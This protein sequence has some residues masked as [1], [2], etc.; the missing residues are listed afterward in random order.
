MQ[1]Q[2]PESVRVISPN[3]EG[4]PTPVTPDLAYLRLGLVNVFYAGHEDAGDR[5]WV[6]IDA[7][8]AGSARRIREGARRRFGRHARPSAILLTH[9]HFD[10]VG[11]LKVLAEDWDVP[12]YAHRLELPYITG[13]SPYPPADPR[14]GRGLI[15][16][17]SPLYPRGPFDF[18]DR[19]QILP[20]DGTVPGLPGWKALHTPGHAPG[21]VAFYDE[22]RKALVAG[23][24]FVT[25]RQES[26]LS[27]ITQK[28]E[29]NGPPAYFTP[30]WDAARRSVQ[31]LADLDLDT[32]A[33]GHGRPFAGP[34][35]GEMVREL[36]RNFDHTARPANGR[37]IARPA[38]MDERGIVSLPP[39]PA[40]PPAMMIALGAAVGIGLAA[41]LLS[42]TR[43]TR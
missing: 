35:V 25:T 1:Q 33:T 27:V 16:F 22:S 23:D 14:V 34:G 41:M 9:G 10:H 15:A 39:A 20:A 8:V 12:I 24:A 36:A 29:L 6:L 38:V 4:A 2:L 18:G 13:R 3:G 11:A 43:H 26:A 31:R 28:P 40:R 17:M 37:Y 42:G 32:I 30:D 19:V 21:H 5:N 7:G